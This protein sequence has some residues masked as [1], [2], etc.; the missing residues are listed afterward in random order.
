M[1]KDNSV[2]VESQR[3]AGAEPIRDILAELFAQYERRFSGINI[4]ITESPLLRLGIP[5]SSDRPRAGP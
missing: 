5:M 3:N 4:V 1:E 2:F